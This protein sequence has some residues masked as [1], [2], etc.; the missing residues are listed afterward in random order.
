[1]K[2]PHGVLLVVSAVLSLCACSM[3][4]VAHTERLSIP[5]S[6]AIPSSTMVPAPYPTPG[7]WQTYTLTGLV[8]VDYPFGDTTGPVVEGTVDIEAGP[9]GYLPETG[10]L[11]V[12]AASTASA[13]I[14]TFCPTHPTTTVAGLPA[15]ERSGYNP[16]NLSDETAVPYFEWDAANQA[17]GIRFVATYTLASGTHTLGDLAQVQDIYMHMLRSLVVPSAYLRAPT[18]TTS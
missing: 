3:S 4:H 14:S 9:S 5:T 7:I 10:L 17:I 6:T 8:S 18:C 12:I 11:V 1:M 16:F 15:G 2:R 13:D